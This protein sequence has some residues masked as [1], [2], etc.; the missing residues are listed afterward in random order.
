MLNLISNISSVHAAAVVGCASLR[1]TL[2]ELLIRRNTLEPTKPAATV[3]SRINHD[4]RH[5]TLT[6]W[7]GF[8]RQE[9][10]NADR[11]AEANQLQNSQMIN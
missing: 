4:T 8:D 1:T 7:R 5:K 6:V 2:I 9:Q 3:I 10:R 11:K